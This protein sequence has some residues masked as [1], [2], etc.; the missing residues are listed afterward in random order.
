MDIESPVSLFN[1]HV[2]FIDSKEREQLFLDLFPYFVKKKIPEDQWLLYLECL[3]AY[4]KTPTS[5]LIKGTLDVITSLPHARQ[6]LRVFQTFC[7][8]HGWVL[9]SFKDLDIYGNLLKNGPSNL[10]LIIEILSSEENFRITN[11]HLYQII[12]RVPNHKLLR[13]FLFYTNPRNIQ[14]NLVHSCFMQQKWDLLVIILQDTFAAR[15]PSFTKAWLC[16][17]EVALHQ[18]KISFIQA[19]LLSSFREKVKAEQFNDLLKNELYSLA[20]LFLRVVPSNFYQPPFANLRKVIW[21]AGKYRCKEGLGWLIKML[22]K[23]ENFYSLHGDIVETIAASLLA[24]GCQKGF[25]AFVRDRSISID[26]SFKYN[27]FTYLHLAYMGGNQKVVQFIAEQYESEFLH[28][29]ISKWISALKIQGIQIE[30]SFL[31]WNVKW[32]DQKLLENTI[33]PD[34]EK[35][36]HEEQLT[37]N[38]NLLIQAIYFD[39]FGILRWILGRLK[40]FTVQ[41]QMTLLYKCIY[42]ASTNRRFESISIFLEK[43]KHLP[44]ETWNNLLILFSRLWSDTEDFYH[45]EPLKK[46][47]TL[48]ERSGQ[49]LLF[50]KRQNVCFLDIVFNI[51][52]QENRLKVLLFFSSWYKPKVWYD[53]FEMHILNNINP[54][55]IAYAQGCLKECLLLANLRTDLLFLRD[56]TGL[57]VLCRACADGKLGF[58]RE[59]LQS[60]SSLENIEGKLL[61]LMIKT[62]SMPQELLIDHHRLENYKIELLR[63]LQRKLLQQYPSTKRGI[64]VTEMALM[65]NKANM[66]NIMKYL[67]SEPYFYVRDNCLHRFHTQAAKAYIQTKN[68]YLQQMLDNTLTCDLSSYFTADLDVLFACVIPIIIE[69][70]LLD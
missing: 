21:S 53:Y 29:K 64:D 47:L 41:Q 34:S 36:T 19:L 28:A 23:K 37:I 45:G 17:F 16:A 50:V 66:T 26:K 24:C 1:G 7:T 27:G 46:L 62:C 6:P 11:C 61:S 67:G 60:L 5:A 63:F 54:V 59:A 48:V 40:R 42:F 32:D 52:N 12:K 15:D 3:Y 8:S 69:Y 49:S 39:S 25:H 31:A 68:K 55:A 22:D 9:S 30:S 56:T 57:S 20:C 14:P 44:K 13:L 33:A 43:L 51:K 10:S 2:A 38:E 70:C 35:R 4:F 18:K 58:V 65:A